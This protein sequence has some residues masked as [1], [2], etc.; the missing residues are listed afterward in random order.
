MNIAIFGKRLDHSDQD[1]F[2]QF[3]STLENS[4][5]EFSIYEPFY[6]GLQPYD[7]FSGTPALFSSYQDIRTNTDVMISVGGDGTLLDS[8]TLIRD[9]SIPVLGLNLGRLGFLS[10]I[11]QEDIISSVQNLVSNNY[12]TE[13]RSLLNVTSTHNL[14]GELN[15]GLND[16]TIHKHDTH[17]LI[18][19]D[20][21]INTVFLNSYWADGL[22]IATP[23]GSTGYSLSCNGPIITPDSSTF[24][25][26][27]IATH[28]LTVR[29]IV[30]PDSSQVSI[31]VRGRE[32][33]FTASLDSRTLL[34]DV[35]EVF[36]IRRASFDVKLVKMPEENFFNT[37]RNKLNWGLDMRN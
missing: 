9:S 23:T 25:I 26:T 24:I 6:T 33:N 22:I 28:N 16:L 27:P 30:L 18:T 11:S 8:I 4:D 36:Q 13:T 3:I 35:S 34:F 20:V 10:S 19:V 31:K 32:E 1:I 21:F 5:A 14:F 15:F 37:L 7:F 2:R 29:P 12:T 17:N